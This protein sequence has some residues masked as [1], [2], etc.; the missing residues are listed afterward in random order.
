MNHSYQNL[1]ISD[2]P[3]FQW[4]GK[5]LDTTAALPNSSGFLLLSDI[6]FSQ[7]EAKYVVANK[8]P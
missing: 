1:K 6:L 3:R 4:I 8:A 2:D 7:G 5:F